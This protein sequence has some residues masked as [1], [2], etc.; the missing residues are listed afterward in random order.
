MSDAPLDDRGLPVGYDFHDDYEI[1]PREAR[2]LL[3]S[4]DV[5]LLDCRTADELAIAS[6][7]GATHVPM[8]EIEDRLDEIEDLER[9]IAVICH[10]GQRSL[11][12]SLML[13][14]H[15]FEDA[16]SVAGGIDLWSRDID[17]SV[18]RYD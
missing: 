13:R 5:A 12:V 10:H 2:E 18:R 14:A 4:G 16:V 8:H 7:D 15:G 6:I 11:R 9:P 17:P 3:A 1:T